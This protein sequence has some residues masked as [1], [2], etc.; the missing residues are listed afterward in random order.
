MK[1]KLEKIINNSKILFCQN[2][3]LDYTI[4]EENG[5]C[6]KPNELC[7]YIDNSTNKYL[8]NKKTLTLIKQ[9]QKQKTIEI[10]LT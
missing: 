7:K 3:P 2:L 10:N 9:K 1:Q 8:C 6:K 5:Y 4:L